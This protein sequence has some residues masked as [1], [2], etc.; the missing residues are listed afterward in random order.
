MKRAP[1]NPLSLSVSLSANQ[2]SD[3][4]AI[5]SHKLSRLLLTHA[6]IGAQ[7]KPK[8]LT[9]PSSILGANPAHN[10]ENKVDSQW[11][12]DRVH[13]S[14]EQLLLE[15]PACWDPVQS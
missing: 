3:L 4:R 13:A 5:W 15:I 8:E 14:D 9:D 7:G 6:D 12:T 10:S 1:I 11:V 2:E